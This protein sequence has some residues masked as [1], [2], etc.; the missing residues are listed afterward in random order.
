MPAARIY[1]GTTITLTNVVRV[2]STPTDAADIAFQWKMGLNGTVTS[3]TPTRTALGTYEVNITPLEGGNL[4][5]R[6]DT[7]GELDTAAEGVLSIADSQFEI[8]A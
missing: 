3:V 4:Y 6:W 7:E 2:G 8:T 1:P 5:Y